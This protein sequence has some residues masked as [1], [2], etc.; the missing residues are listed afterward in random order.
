VSRKLGSAGLTTTGITAKKPFVVYWNNIPSPYMVD[1]FNALADRDS[2]DFCVWFNDRTVEDR[3]WTVD[4]S[5]WRFKYRYIPRTSF[6]GWTVH[7]PSPVL[8]RRPDLLVS[9]YSE[10]SFLLGWAIARVR[11]AK[12]CF[13][14]LATYDKW[15][16]RRRFKEI[17][18]GWLF[19]CVD[20][21]ETPG[22]DGRRYAMKYGVP[23]DRVFV[24]THTIAPTL[25]RQCQLSASQA[26]EFRR[27]LGVRGTVFLYV[28]R[29]WW[30]K[31]L[32]YLLQAFQRVQRERED[33]SLLI[34]G[35]GPDLDLLEQQ[36]KELRLSGVTFVGFKQREALPAY[37]AA[38][39]VLV[40]PTLG[41]PYGLVVDEALACSVPVI[42]TDAVGEIADRIHEGV[43]G[44]IVPSEDSSA[45]AAAMG[46][47]AGDENLR[48]SMASAAAARVAERTPERWATEFENMAHEVLAREPAISPRIAVRWP[49]AADVRE[50]NSAGNEKPA[51]A[52]VWSSFGP[53]HVSRCEGVVAATQKYEVVGIELAG[54]SRTYPWN[55]VTRDVSFVRRT[56]SAGAVE[57]LSPLRAFVL[58]RRAFKDGG[59]TAAFLESYW[60]ARNL[61]CFAAA[62]SLGLRTIMMNESH[63][64]TAKARG[65][66]LSIKKMLVRRFDAALVGGER[67][68]QYFASLGLPRDR[69]FVGYDAVDNHYF[70]QA[71]ASVRANAAALR[72]A[73][74]LPRRYV[75]SVGRMVSKKN[76]SVLIRASALLKDAHGSALPV[77]FVGSGVE[78]DGL[79]RLAADLG[80]RV[81]DRTVDQSTAEGDVL[82]YGFRQID[83]N[84]VFYALAEAF[85]LPSI[86][87]E[88]GLVVNEAMACATPVIVSHNAG[89]AELVREGVNGYRFDAT[90]PEDLARV[91]DAFVADTQLTNR[92]GQTAA[93]DIKHWGCERFGEE[94]LHAMQTLEQAC[95][96]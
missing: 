5:T 11:G 9:L 49:A 20:A 36:C 77:V 10:P 56:L 67:H 79:K 41:D 66:A 23:E 43:N 91:L 8:G 95:A 47:L 35:D 19:R 73:Y 93:A 87:E 57:D 34:V 83:E 7:W 25:A 14:V 72:A 90:T 71:A 30:G 55:A 63:D 53:Y 85:V 58:L 74:G 86:A 92:L 4:E 89:A 1:R 94:V 29:L 68:R 96:S 12:T 22:N 32:H 62:K 54:Q 88:W 26:V 37:Y 69:I 48:R 46:R 15:V 28:G 17:L 27:E 60:P 78:E 16:R 51:V 75:L 38:A 45:L 2:I 76:L 42:S 59:C 64:G 40:F 84:P 31:G 65:L 33:V 3:S 81:I 61:A 70:E 13:R 80:L 52:V 21:A 39:D 44:L 24:A 6:A 18:K 50:A 82:F